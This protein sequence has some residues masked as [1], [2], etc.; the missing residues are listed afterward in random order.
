MVAEPETGR[1]HHQAPGDTGNGHIY[2]N[3][4]SPELAYE[5][6][7]QVIPIWFTDGGLAGLTILSSLLVASFSTLRSKALNPPNPL[8]T[9]MIF[10][11]GFFAM[12]DGLR[13][14]ARTV[15]IP[16]HLRLCLYPA[17]GRKT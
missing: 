3:I 6:L 17:S 7:S 12:R 5:W 10:A 11:A 2:A 16:V 13:E 9:F 15:H 8:I 1:I 14:R 4:E